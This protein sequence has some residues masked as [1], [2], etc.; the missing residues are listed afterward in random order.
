VH[1]KEAAR[2]VN[3]TGHKFDDVLFLKRRAEFFQRRLNFRRERFI[4]RFVGQF[5]QSAEVFNSGLELFPRL[6]PQL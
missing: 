4:F 2:A 6:V 3:L 5:Q 1:S